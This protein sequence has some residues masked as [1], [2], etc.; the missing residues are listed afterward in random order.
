MPHEKSPG[1]SR[2]QRIG[3]EGLL[4]LE[5]QLSSGTR[6][7]S[8]VLSQWVKR[9]GDPARELIDRY[10]QSYQEADNDD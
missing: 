1:V 9:Y 3:D 6:L 7:S 5:K 8:I 2:A 10:G 4:R